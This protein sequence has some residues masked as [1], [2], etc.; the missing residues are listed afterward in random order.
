VSYESPSSTVGEDKIPAKRYFTDWYAPDV[1]LVKTLVLSGG[2]DGRELA[3]IELLRFAKLVAAST[4]AAVRSMTK[5]PL[6]GK[7]AN[8]AVAISS[9]GHASFL[10]CFNKGMEK[11]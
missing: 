9:N 6:L 3:R 8:R 1:G 11:F 5:G 10:I 4:T 7:I 2:Q